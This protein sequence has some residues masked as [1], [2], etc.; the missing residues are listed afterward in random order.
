MTSCLLVSKQMG[1]NTAAYFAL[2]R[3]S[4]IHY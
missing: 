2:T 1:R 4:A 3:C